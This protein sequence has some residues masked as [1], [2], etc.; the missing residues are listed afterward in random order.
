MKFYGIE[1]KGI[2]KAEIMSSLPVFDAE[3][4]GRVV[5]LSTNKKIYLNNGTEYVLSSGETIVATLPTFDASQ[6]GWLFYAEDTNHLYYNNGTEYVLSSGAVLS[7]TT[8]PAFDAD[9]AGWLFY[10]EDTNLLYYNNGTEQLL[11]T[12]TATKYTHTQT[13]ASATWTVTHS[14]GNQYVSVIC[15][16]ATDNQLLPSTVIFTNT[17]SLI[18]TFGVAISG[19]AIIIG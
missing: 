2:F 17:T 15:V 9:Q 7:V 16:G 5:Y 8:L 3:D 4:S 12:P 10:A 19:K 11:L 13:E 18:I 1:M 14:L 6:E